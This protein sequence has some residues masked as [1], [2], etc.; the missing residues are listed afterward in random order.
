[1]FHFRQ[2]LIVEWQLGMLEDALE[3]NPVRQHQFAAKGRPAGDLPLPGLTV[4]R[5]VQRLVIGDLGL[6]VIGVIPGASAL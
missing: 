3:R 5:H 4:D 1:M 2:V 6:Q